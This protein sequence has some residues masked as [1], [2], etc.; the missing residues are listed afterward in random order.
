MT[1][2]I[3]ELIDKIDVVK[4]A[5]I[6]FLS[7][8]TGSV[9]YRSDTITSIA[10]VTDPEWFCNIAPILQTTA[11]LGAIVVAAFT[12]IKLF[13]DLRRRKKEKKYFKKKD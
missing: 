7:A 2:L 5:V 8:L 3:L 11:W 13:R 4:G 10:K 12:T 6:S 1:R 9:A